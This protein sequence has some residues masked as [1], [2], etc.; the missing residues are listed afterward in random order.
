LSLGQYCSVISFM[1]Y[2]LKITDRIPWR[3]AKTLPRLYCQNVIRFN[4]I[5][6]NVISY[7]PTRKLRLSL[8]RLSRKISNAQQRDRQ[9]SYTEFQ[10]NWTIN[11][12]STDRNLFR[13]LSK[14][15]FSLFWFSRKIHSLHKIFVG[16]SSTTLFQTG[17]KCGICGKVF[18]YVF[19]NVCLLLQHE[20]QNFPNVYEE[21]TWWNLAVC[22]LV[23][24][25]ILYMFRTLFASILRST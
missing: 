11:V 8:H 9:I 22:L 19:K 23:T 12:A 21:P 14:I 6:V 16:I 2:G 13:P 4:T 3:D 15:R 7:K 18:V 24:A 20:T 25:I 17:W 1:A 10:L 5:H